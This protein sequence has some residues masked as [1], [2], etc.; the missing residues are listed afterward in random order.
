MKKVNKILIIISIV[1]LIVGIISGCGLSI[2]LEKSIPN[3]PINVDGTDFSGIVEVGGVIVSKILGTM[4]VICSIGVVGII[5][6][7]YAIIVLLVRIIKKVK[8]KS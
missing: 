2:E 6:I 3:E 4:I 7:I 1:I 5:W 8:N